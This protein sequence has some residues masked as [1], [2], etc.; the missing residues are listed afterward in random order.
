MS[1]Y[2]CC[3]ICETEKNK[4]ILI[5]GKYLRDDGKGRQPGN[6]AYGRPCL[7][8][9]KLALPVALRVLRKRFFYTNLVPVQHHKML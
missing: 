4:G 1:A 9:V 7:I 5:L 2:P 3:R 8:S 6:M